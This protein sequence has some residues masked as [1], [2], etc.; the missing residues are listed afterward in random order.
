MVGRVSAALVL[1]CGGE[2]T[3]QP[4]A[5]AAPVARPAFRIV[6]P[7]GAA[8][9]T[10]TWA[11]DARTLGAQLVDTA[12]KATAAT[13]TWVARDTAVVRVS[14]EGVVTAQNDGATWVVALATA[15]AANASDSTPVVVRRRAA[16]IDVRASLGG[17][18]LAGSPPALAIA[19]THTLRLMA[20]VVD[21]GNTPIPA[22]RVSWQSSHPDVV[23][24]DTAGLLT[25]VAP[26]AATVTVTVAAGAGAI[27]RSI[28][29]TTTV[30][31]LTVDTDTIDVG[32]GQLTSTAY[33]PGPAVALEAFGDGE[34]VV[35]TMAA[36]DTS[37]VAVPAQVSAFEPSTGST[38]GLVFAGRRPGLAR[39][40][41]TAPGFTSASTVVRVTAPR[42]HLGLVGTP[43][44]T[45]RVT[46]GAWPSV[47]LYTT[48]G[49]GNA[50]RVQ[51]RLPLTA[52][53]SDPSVAAP[54][55]SAPEGWVPQGEVNGNVQLVTQ[56]PGQAWVRVSAPG[57]PAESLA[58]VVAGTP[59][60]PQLRVTG[61][62]SYA[63][64]SLAG[65][66]QVSTPDQLVLSSTASPPPN[67]TV[68]LTQR[69]PEV[70]R[71]PGSLPLAPDLTTG[72][73]A[74]TWAGLAVGADTVVASVP[75]FE[76]ATF[77]LRVTTPR[78]V[79][80]GAPTS[81]RVTAPGTFV[82]VVADSTGAQHLPLDGPVSLTATPSNPALLQVLDPVVVGTTSSGSLAVRVRFFDVGTGT[83]TLSDPAGRYPAVTLPPVT[84]ASTPMVVAGGGG[85]AGTGG[86]ARATLGMGQRL[87]GAS[88]VTVIPSGGSAY[89]TD[90]HVRTTNARLVRAQLLPVGANAYGQRGVA[91][92]GGD[93]TGSGWVVFTAAGLQPDS[94]RVDVGRGALGVG[95]VAPAAGR[96][97]FVA[98]DTVTVGLT[99]LDPA[100]VGRPTDQAT[101]V[102]LT[103]TDTTVAVPVAGSV[104][105][106]AGAT[107]TTTRVALRAAGSV[108]LRARDANPG[109]ARAAD[110]V[111]AGITVVAP[112]PGGP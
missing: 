78:L 57:Y 64:V 5:G 17:A 56:A 59:S 39:V 106:P 10:L 74:F 42:L 66:R 62:P 81:G 76:S 47:Y 104:L 38:V 29:V 27:T 108:V 85:T 25:A 44:P 2:Q 1:G 13:A 41:I 7:A 92:V 31:S 60:A 71:V 75:G 21:S 3:T 112:P 22:A 35:L 84:V 40:T 65:A 93:T 105:I 16:R 91:L 6:P 73:R 4:R 107:G 11:G 50:R 102:L 52:V 28:A 101:T 90:L 19:V 23:T 67:V 24:A 97:A 55:Y 70:A 45:I 88:G 46:A 103:S 18:V 87:D 48:D 77:V 33:A 63:G 32:V 110:G 89:D 86:T 20:G 34:T 61:G 109:Y 37:V 51:S 49:R 111:S 36:S 15:P 58:V 12:G 26:G 100:G 53:S 94:L 98:G 30:R 82:V 69:H 8:P 95:P 43:D 14:Q 83:V 80:Q 72:V 96:S 79:V 9:D 54:M 99:V 68:T